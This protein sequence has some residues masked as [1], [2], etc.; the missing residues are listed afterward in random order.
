MAP[1]VLLISLEKQPHF[2]ESYADLLAALRAKSEMLEATSPQIALDFLG[3]P[4]PIAAVLV[5]DPGLIHNNKFIKLLSKVVA[6]AREGGTLIFCG[7]CSSLGKFPA[8]NKFFERTLCV[9]WRFGSYTGNDFVLNNRCSTERFRK[10]STMPQKYLMIAVHLF[11]VPVESQVYIKPN[12]S[13]LKSEESPI[14]FAKY[15]LG[16]V[17]WSGQVSPDP[18]CADVIVA[19]CNLQDG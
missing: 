14:V 12:I 8:F 5:T 9:R 18:L 19:M 7:H 16:H 11:G 10:L 6:Y 17:G 4:T 13:P 3:L 2:D 1:R 15:G